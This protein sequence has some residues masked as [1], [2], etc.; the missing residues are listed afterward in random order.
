[1]HHQRKS[2]AANLFH[3]GPER[4]AADSGLRLAL[5]VTS[6]GDDVADT[7]T[8]RDCGVERRM[9]TAFFYARSNAA[10]PRSLEEA[11]Q[12]RRTAPK[13]SKTAYVDIGM[14]RRNIAVRMYYD[15]GQEEHCCSTLGKM[16]G[17]QPRCRPL[18]SL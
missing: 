18:L 13:A 16:R 1:M 14:F 17:A 5:G 10:C 7:P 3:R 4:A 6:A 12:T 8:I 15:I 9:P 2:S 11:Y